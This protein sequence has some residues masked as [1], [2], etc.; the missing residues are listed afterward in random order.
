ME[1]ATSI[2]TSW[3]CQ[4]PN[5]QRFSH[6]N[7]SIIDGNLMEYI[8]NAVLLKVITLLCWLMCVP[9]VSSVESTTD[10]TIIIDNND[11]QTVM[12]APNRGDWTG[13]DH[14]IMVLPW[15]DRQKGIRFP[16]ILF[17]CIK[18]Q[19]LVLQL[20]ASTSIML[21]WIKKFIFSMSW[22]TKKSSCLFRVRK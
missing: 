16:S 3:T 7:S 13:G 18:Y 10:L 12:C 2:F 21:N 6:F 1:I 22:S 11:E 9:T 19:V 17:F 4:R 15:L 20:L 8:T 14:V 5:L